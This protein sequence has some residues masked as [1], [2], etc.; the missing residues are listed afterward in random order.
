MVGQTSLVR[1]APT[2]PVE[3][4]GGAAPFAGVTVATGTVP[5]LLWSGGYVI[6]TLFQGDPA[7]VHVSLLGRPAGPTYASAFAGSAWLDLT[8]FVAVPGVFAGFQTPL[9]AKGTT[10]A[11]Q[12]ASITPAGVEL[13]NVV[14]ATVP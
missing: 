7:A 2:V 3:A 11:M 5:A 6:N 1:I 13:S 9:F 12:V 14:V 10:V 4:R 8:S